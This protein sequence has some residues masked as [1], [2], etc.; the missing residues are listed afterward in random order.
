MIGK[1]LAKRDRPDIVGKIVGYDAHFDDYSI[2]FMRKDFG[3]EKWTSDWS[4]Y[5]LFKNLGDDWDVYESSPVMDML[6]GFEN[7]T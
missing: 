2:V 3:S 6:M 1:L 4:T 7:D 5:L